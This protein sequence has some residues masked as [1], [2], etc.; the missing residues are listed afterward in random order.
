MLRKI[1]KILKSFGLPSILLVIVATTHLSYDLIGSLYDNPAVAAKAWASVLRAFPE[2]TL[3]YLIV[4]MLVPWEPIAVRLGA[5]VVCAW[6]AVE[7]FQ[8]AACRLQFPMGLPPPS[9]KPYTG[10]C[11]LVTGWP[12]YMITIGILLFVSV[13]SR[14]SNEKEP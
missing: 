14:K 4:W 5:S 1:V 2:A 8:I 9:V 10:L 13:F 6:G 3:L 7:S 11:D 12:I